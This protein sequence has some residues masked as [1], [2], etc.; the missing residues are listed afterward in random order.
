M[1]FQKLIIH[2]IASIEDATIDFEN[3]PLSED[4][5]FLICGPTG[6]GKTTILDAICLALYGTTPRLNIKKVEAYVDQYENYK[7]KDRDEVKI[8]DT[9]MMM[10]RGSLSA[11]V[12]LYFTDKDECPLK[13]V[14]Q[15]SR[16]RN[17]L[18]GN[19]K[20]P[21]WLL[22]DGKTD[23][24]IDDRKSNVLKEISRRIGLTFEQFCRTTMLAQ[25][26]FTKFLKSDEGEKSQILEKLTGT[27]IYSE[28]SV[29]IHQLKNEKE[30]ACNQITSMMQGVQL[31]SD[32]DVEEILQQQKEQEQKNGF[33]CYVK[34]TSLKTLRLL[35]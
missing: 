10:R 3:G 6:A 29:R 31:L 32:T 9:R 21:E 34:K 30:A 24:L 12:E 23:T 14:W 13:A 2:N 22:F 26:E 11:F 19:V 8:D 20:E 17:N 35:T 25:G 33:Y 27:T 16:V 28:V 18:Q 4:S 7:L 1:K 5:R 15:C